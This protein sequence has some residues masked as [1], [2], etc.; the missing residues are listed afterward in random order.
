MRG[1]AGLITSHTDKRYLWT[2]GVPEHLNRRKLS[3]RVFSLIWRCQ[4]LTFSGCLLGFCADLAAG[5]LT[6]VIS[7]FYYKFLKNKYSS[8]AF[9]TSNFF[10]RV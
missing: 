9:V 2:A 6:L 8:F 1:Y 4:C 10:V 7:E 5:C 3:D